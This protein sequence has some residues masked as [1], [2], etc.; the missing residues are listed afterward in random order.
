[1]VLEGIIRIYMNN[2]EKYDKIFIDVFGVSKNDLGDSFT[3]KDNPVWDSVA[4]L[5]LISE[6]EDQFDILFETED[7][8]HYESYSNGIRILKKYGV[9][10]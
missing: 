9:E 6:L 10:F 3:F 8:L 5:N 2:K 4:H 1:M 7:I